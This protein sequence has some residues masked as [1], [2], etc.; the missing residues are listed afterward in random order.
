[1]PDSP[2]T[3]KFL[4]DDEKRVTV[5]RL[6]DNQTGVENKELKPYQVWEAF[7]DPKLYMFYILGTV[8]NAPNGGLSNFQ[9]LIV[10]G[11]VRKLFQS[12][13]SIVNKIF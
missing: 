10:S 11:I 12:G 4:S 9:T 8:C 13:S 5:I 1:M 6:K 3:A 7:K 2:V